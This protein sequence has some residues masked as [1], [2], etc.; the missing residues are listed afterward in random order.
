M[1]PTC[2]VPDLSLNVGQV[3]NQGVSWLSRNIGNAFS[4]TA[5]L[6]LSLVVGLIAYF[7]FLKD[8]ARFLKTIV[9]MSPLGDKH[10]I[11]ILS[12]LSNTIHSVIRGSLTIALIQGILTCIGFVIFGVPNPVLWGS[13]A[14]I[15]ALVPGVGTTIVLLP[16]IIYLFASGSTGAGIGLLLWGVVAVGLID[17]LLMPRLVGSRAKIHSLFILISVLG[18]LAFFGPSG[19]LLGPLVVSLVYG[20][21]ETYLDLFK[22]D[23]ELASTEVSPS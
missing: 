5:Q 20:L 19:F 1:Y 9:H 10:D 4:V 8:G 7:F 6:V 23:I 16:A 14:A 2:Y 12:K 13:V 18:G 21:A 15:G 17:N 3:V 11:A 22:R